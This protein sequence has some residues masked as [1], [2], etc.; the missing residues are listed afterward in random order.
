MTASGDG[1]IPGRW[2]RSCLAPESQI[3]T[4]FLFECGRRPWAKWFE[5]ILDTFGEIGNVALHDVSHDLGVDTEVSVNRSGSKP[6]NVIPW[7]LRVP[8]L[9]VGRQTLGGFGDGL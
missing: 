7:N 6:S 4:S 8:S 1:S 2:W 9:E 3:G 5:L